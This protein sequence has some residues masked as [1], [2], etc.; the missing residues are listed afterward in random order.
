MEEKPNPRLPSCPR[1]P[2][3]RLHPELSTATGQTQDP[4]IS[5]SLENLA[6]SGEVIIEQSGSSSP[7]NQSDSGSDN[8][9]D[10]KQP[11]HP[12]VPVIGKRIF[13]PPRD[14]QQ[15]QGTAMVALWKFIS[16]PIFRGSPTEEACQWL[17][18]YETISTH[19]SWGDA[20]KRHNFSM[21]LDDTVRN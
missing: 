3:R 15:L 1:D 7:E 14:Q 8:E 5:T 11:T 18:R 4:E 9:A 19:N 17:E 2:S 12:V 20:N 13:A 16:P 6:T 10:L 21:F